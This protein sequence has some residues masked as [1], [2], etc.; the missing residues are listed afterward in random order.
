V[1]TRLAPTPSGYLHLGN[2]VNF[3]LVSWLAE[4]EGAEV[5][6]RIDDVDATR[7][8]PEYVDDIFDV[9]EWMG[10]SWDRG[11]R[12]REEFDA[13]FS[14]GRRTA[15]Y[16]AALDRAQA[17][18]LEAY[19]CS[20]S[21]SAQRGVP[22]GGCAARCRDSQLTFEPGATSLRV[23][24][25]RGTVVSVEGRPVHVDR[26]IG[27]FVVWRR[28]DMPAYHLA[29][30]VEDQE[31]GITHV[32]RGHD[33]RPSTAAQLFLARPLE[34]T[35]FASAV[36]LHHPLVADEQGRKL[37]KSQLTTGSPLECT[38][39]TRRRIHDLAAELAEP[40]GIQPGGMRARPV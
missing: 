24:V 11:P 17:G 26:E 21:R 33:L 8:R 1:R 23:H 6:L 32:V 37:S 10:I 7:H 39:A 3:Q 13:H 25:P 12:S 38:A 2:A 15:H 22:T 40:L 19:A 30:V 29:S 28:D 4:Q 27:D 20:C 5:V 14:L 16:R 9:L 31:N 36:F 35:A 34:A 18:G